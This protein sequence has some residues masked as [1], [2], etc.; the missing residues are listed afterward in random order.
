MKSWQGWTLRLRTV[1]VSSFADCATA[2]SVKEVVLKIL[3]DLSG[4]KQDA[5][6]WQDG[7]VVWSTDYGLE[8]LHDFEDVASDLKKA[9][10]IVLKPAARA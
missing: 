1:W 2:A 3:A 7:E 5:S 10:V 8:D 6:N 4:M 9:A